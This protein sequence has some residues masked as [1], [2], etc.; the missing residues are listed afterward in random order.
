MSSADS[1]TDGLPAPTTP[2]QHVVVIFDENVSFDHYFATYPFAT[3][4]PG[5]PRF[6]ALPGTPT[7]NGLSSGLLIANPNLDNP[8]RLDPSQALTCD[9]NHGYT[10]E[11]EAYDGGLMD[12]F[13][14]DTTG[15]GCSQT[16]YPNES[17]YGPNGIVMDYYD[18]NTVTGLWN[19]AQHFALSDDSFDTQ[20]GPSSPGAINL[21]SGQTNGA[22]AEGGTTSSIANGTLESDQD[23][24][25]DQCSNP[26]SPLN[27]NGSPGGVTAE[28]TGQ[29]VGNLMNTKGVTWGWFQGGFTPSS[30]SNGRPI[31]GTSHENVG[32][33]TVTDYVQH[34]EPFQFYASTS[35]PD[36]V[37]P[38]SVSDV[39]VGDP[40]GTAPANA[41]NHQYDLS[42][43]N[44]S[45]QAGDLPQV[46]FLKPPAYENAHAGNSDPLDEQR[47][48]ADT[49][50]SIE[51]SKYWPNT[52]IIIDY[53]DSDGWYDH[54]MGPIVRPSQD[55]LDALNGAG[56]CGSSAAPPAQ[57]DRCGVG[58]RLPLLVI[59]PWAK[60]N[61]VDNT[62]TE[63][64]SILRF[65]EDNWNLGR[66][67]NGSADETAGTL[68]DMFDFN[69]NDPRSPGII[70]SD[71]TGE[72]TGVIPAGSSKVITPTTFPVPDTTGPSADEGYTG[73]G[74]GGG[75]PTG[76][77]GPSGPSGPS[78]PWGQNGP[79]GGNGSG[80]LPPIGGGPG[81]GTGSGKG[82]SGSGSGKGSGG[83]VSC[84]DS[85]KNG[86]LT[87][88]CT[89]AETKGTVALRLRLYHGTSLVGDAAGDVRENRARLVISLGKHAKKGHYLATLS[90]D[91][92]GKLTA[93]ERRL[94]LA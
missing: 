92:N 13:V 16:T 84:A 45:L 89:A 90:V 9:Q 11:Q 51:Q 22:I 1:S 76:P 67:G 64:A 43:F 25:F 78:G 20:F 70:L 48:I 32:G 33:A 31:C 66:I 53:D 7:V 54:Q 73:G 12:K 68:D 39:G 41:V 29:N 30:I 28:L 80:G 38:A 50:D 8:Q 21:I 35:N 56:R 3:N 24:Y 47:W 46:S 60:Q 57:N 34:H 42:W 26:T 49:V 87:V 86:R 58:P 85:W 61:F 59:S 81:P 91:S 36:H 37:A 79:G 62:F 77:G 2:I 10:N 27:A 72:I 71:S 6:E 69:P 14:Q 65:I 23:P 83:S 44:A 82:G 74:G 93:Q 75:Q 55:S 94:T 5:E 17:S 40:A 18:G 4:P 88:I 19:L 52:A 63:Q 15:S